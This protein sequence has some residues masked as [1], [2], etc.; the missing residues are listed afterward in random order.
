M[1]KMHSKILV[2]IATLG[3]VGF[4]PKAPGTWGSA[5]AAIGA[6][7]CFYPFPFTVKVLILA[8]IFI[9]GA[10]ACSE[11]EVQL[12]KKDPGCVII[13]EVLGQWITYLPFGMMTGSQLIIGF[14]FFRIFDILKPWPI[15]QSEKWLKSG[16]G[17]MIDDV[18]AGVYAAI[19]LW[20]FRMI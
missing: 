17:V 3:P 1:K 20:L 19:A 7:F 10:I 11:A 8:F 16:W 6:P 4:L 5:V 13:D 12:G 18:L 15:K 9:F 2:N 14:V